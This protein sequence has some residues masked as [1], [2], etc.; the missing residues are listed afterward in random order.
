[1]KTSCLLA[2]SLS[3]STAFL[4]PS[5]SVRTAS[6]ELRMQTDN[7]DVASRKAFFK[8]I[9]VTGASAAAVFGLPFAGVLRVI[10]GNVVMF[11]GLA[12]VW[13]IIGLISSLI[14]L[15]PPP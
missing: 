10:S 13:S 6:P 9:S 5:D 2:A 3:L 1:M 15:G 8:Q 7:N 14:L 12:A 11:C 4:A